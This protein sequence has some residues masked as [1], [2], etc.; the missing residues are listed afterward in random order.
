MS[1]FVYVCLFVY[2]SVVCAACFRVYCVCVVYVVCGV[3]S[4][5]DLQVSRGVIGWANRVVKLLVRDILE[6]GRRDRGES[7]EMKDERMKGL[8][9]M[10]NE[11]DKGRGM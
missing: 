2:V 8:G 6:G 11:R 5:T 10:R 1:T 4:L 9:G 3:W 7:G